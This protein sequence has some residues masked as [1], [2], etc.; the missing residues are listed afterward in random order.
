MSG[1]ARGLLARLL[2]QP[3]TVVGTAALMASAWPGVLR[4]EAN[5]RVQMAAL[6]RALAATPG[7]GR[8]ILNIPGRGYQFALPV[9]ALAEPPA[10]LS[11]ADEAAGRPPPLLVPLIGRKA[12][13]ALL[14]QRLTERRL[15]TLTGAGGI[16]KTSLAL[17]AAAAWEAVAPGRRVH[18]LDLATI[19]EESL[20]PAAV[21]SAFGLGTPGIDPVAEI[22]I[23]LRDRETLLLLDGA[24]HLALAAG[25]LAVRLLAGSLVLRLLATSREALQAPGE[26]LHPLAPLA[27]PPAEAPASLAAVLAWPAAQ[28]FVQRAAA[29]LGEFRPA[30]ADAAALAGLCRRL[31]GL[32]LAIGLAAARIDMFGI[33]GLAAGMA[34][35]LAVSGGARRGVAPRHRTMRAT[36]DWSHDAL[37]PEDRRLLR[38]LS[39]FAG[40]F[41]AE[42]VHAVL[43]EPDPV[44]LERALRRLEGKSLLVPAGAADETAP[45]R[46]LLEITRAYAAEKLA[47]SGEAAAMQRRHAL[48]VLAQVEAAEAARPLLPLP[49]WR[50][51]HDHLPYEL[52]AATD[53][54]FGPSGEAALGLRL[55]AG[56]API[57]LELNAM[58]EYRQR[59]ETALARLAATGEARTAAAARLHVAAGTAILHNTGEVTLMTEHLRQAIEI[60]DAAGDA[61]LAIT[62]TAGLWMSRNMAGEVA[63]NEAVVADMG[64]R[65]AVLPAPDGRLARMHQRMASLTAYF[66]GDLA[67]ARRLVDARL[68]DAEEADR[69][70]MPIDLETATLALHARLLWLEGRPAQAW[71]VARAALRR[72]EVVDRPL[73]LAYCLTFAACPVAIW[74][75]DPAAAALAARLTATGLRHRM[76]YWQGWGRCFESALD[77]PPA[78]PR[79]LELTPFH[80]E[81]LGTIHPALADPAT[82]ARA[83]AGLAPW[84]APELLRVKAETLLQRAGGEPGVARVAERILREAL[85]LAERRGMHAWALRCATSLARLLRR[86]GEAGAARALLAP[87]VAAR[88]EGQELPD[89]RAARQ[90]LDDAAA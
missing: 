82:I 40:P 35:L 88:T 67:T 19:S 87:V 16:G 6:R 37:S 22:G 57:W 27:V 75:G 53:W 71:D 89:L 50:A 25:D 38:R 51:R 48:Q 26:W 83:E 23:A 34:D 9:R 86:G 55:L 84:C 39:V 80:L 52:R 36:L 30:E 8:A 5:L 14:A 73:T 72:A 81:L 46:R 58:A 79:G 76:P 32:P 42:A 78:R 18:F 3:G 64:R 31:D 70:D 4:L 65:I 63:A 59:L 28:L 41:T 33:A 61:A 1:P 47:G 62:A 54:A 21:A 85:A 43:D 2:E 74:N 49:A 7:G 69:H 29:R 77:A 12:E 11:V 60:A 10:L 17:A 15:L 90:V 66:A 13:L 44:T 45:R 68:R 24:E 20:L 56:S